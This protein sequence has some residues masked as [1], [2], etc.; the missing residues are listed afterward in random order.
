MLG[1]AWLTLTELENIYIK[2]QEHYRLC[3]ILLA[4]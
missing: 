3:I 4:K 1:K 2:L